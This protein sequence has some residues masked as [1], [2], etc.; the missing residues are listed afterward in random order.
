MEGS[1]MSAI[2]QYNA[3][4]KA[5][6]RKCVQLERKYR[7]QAATSRLK[8]KARDGRERDVYLRE[9]EELEHRAYLAKHGVGVVSM[10]P[11]VMPV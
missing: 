9:A 10:V 6:E 7:A 11:G 8:A 3:V 1:M 4:D 5:F 2:E